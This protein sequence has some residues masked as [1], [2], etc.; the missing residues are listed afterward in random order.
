MLPSL[1]CRG[2]VLKKKLYRLI[3]EFYSVAFID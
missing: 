1:S 2:G 3:D